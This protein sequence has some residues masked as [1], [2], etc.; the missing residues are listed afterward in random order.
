[1]SALANI[2][3]ATVLNRETRGENSLY[4]VAFSPEHAIVQAIKK[5]PAKRTGTL[6]DIFDDIS[7]VCDSASPTALKFIREFSV[8]KRRHE[9][10]SDYNSFAQ[11]ALITQTVL[12]N[13]RHIEDSETLSKRLRASLDS[14]VAGAPAEAVR[15]KFMYLLARDEGYPVHE[16]FLRRLTQKEINTFS[17]IIKTPSR[18]LAAL[19]AEASNLLEALCGWICSNTDIA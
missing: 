1:M 18:E 9:I 17:T 2:N 10:A 15:L 16:D 6:P 11:A 4:I 7:A 13:G 3:C 12:K 8:L 19:K 14:I 5:I